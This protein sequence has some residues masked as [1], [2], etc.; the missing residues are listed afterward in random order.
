MNLK[1]TLTGAA[2]VLLFGVAATPNPANAQ[3]AAQGGGYLLR[4]KWTPGQSYKYDVVTKVSIGGKGAKPIEQH[5]PYVMKVLTVKN[6]VATLQV[7]ADV[8][9]LVGGKGQSINNTLKVDS[10]GKILEGDKSSVGFFELPE[11]PVKLNTPW[12]SNQSAQ[13]PVG[14]MAIK[15]TYKLTGTKTV[16]GKKMLVVATTTSGTSSTMNTSGGGTM[17][18]EMKDGMMFSMDSVQ[19]MSIKGAPSTSGGSGAPQTMPVSVSV[20]RIP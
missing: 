14:K 12:T 10:R 13:T 11:K 6:G 15:A 17:L 7:K 18:V 9:G 20:K 1:L 3:V 5:S 2:L 16:N 8:S 4:I 19:N